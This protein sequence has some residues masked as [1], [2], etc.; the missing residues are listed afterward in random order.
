LDLIAEL[1]T[2]AS[3]H[4]DARHVSLRV[5]GL[6]DRRLRIEAAD[7]GAGPGEHVR[8]GQGLAGVRRWHGEWEIVALVPRG[9]RVSILLSH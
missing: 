9:A 7:D 3:R 8:E 6:D 2:N 4:G 5:V 1:V